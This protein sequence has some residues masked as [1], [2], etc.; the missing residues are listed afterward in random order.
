MKTV[1][2]TFTVVSAETAQQPHDRSVKFIYFSQTKGNGDMP[3][4]S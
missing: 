2:V 1:F 3:V 4:E